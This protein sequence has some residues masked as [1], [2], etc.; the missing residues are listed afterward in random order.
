MAP[1]W[2]AYT[3]IQVT[4]DAAVVCH[5]RTY[6][7]NGMMM[8]C[9]VVYCAKKNMIRHGMKKKTKIQNMFLKIKIHVLLPIQKK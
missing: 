3:N 4:D 1:Q 7:F 9:T 5:S 2:M 6:T 8:Q